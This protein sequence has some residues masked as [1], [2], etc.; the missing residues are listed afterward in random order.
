L[1]KDFKWADVDH[2][3][4]M[5]MDHSKI[6]EETRKILATEIVNHP[7]ALN[8]LPGSF[9]LN[10]LRGLFEAVFDRPIDRGTFRRKMLK[11]GILEQVARRKDP[12]GRPSHLFRFNRE[13]YQR[14][15][16]EDIRFGF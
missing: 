13:A 10:E 3:D 12:V 2:L 16:K 5:A 7:I 8:L 11:L 6:V 4:S 14:F 1:L 15:L 9:T